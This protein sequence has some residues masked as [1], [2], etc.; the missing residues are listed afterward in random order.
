MRDVIWRQLL[1]ECRGTAIM[2]HMS[3]NSASILQ[4]VFDGFYFIFFALFYFLLCFFIS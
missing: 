1:C 3:V 4:E 2:G